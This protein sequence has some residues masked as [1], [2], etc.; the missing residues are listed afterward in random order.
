MRCSATSG[1]HGRSKSTMRRQ[2]SKLRPSPPHSVE[3]SR[4]GPSASRNCATSMSR[5]AV[6]SPSWKTAVASCARWLRAVRSHSSVSRWATNTS[7]LSPAAR[8]SRACAASHARRGSSASAS[9]ARALSAASSRPR[10]AWSDTP[11]ASARRT[12]SAFWRR[13]QRV[14][15]LRLAH[16]VHERE[17][18]L[19][20]QSVAL[21][22][23]SHARRQAADVHAPGGARAGRQRLGAREPRL[24]ALGFGEV[25]GPQQLQQPEEAVHVV[26]ERDRREQQQVASERRDRG[27]R[28]PGRVAGMARRPPQPVR[29]VDHQQVDASLGRPGGELGPRDERFDR[30]HGARVHLERVEVGAEVARH[31][32]EAGVV[33]QHEDLVV[34]PPQLAQPLHRERLG[35][36]HEAALGASGPDEAAQHQ[37]GLD[38]LA[39]A[40]LVGEEPAHRVGRG[41]PL[42]RVELVREEPDPPAQERSRGRSPRGA[43]RGGARR[44]AAPGPRPGRGRVSRGV[45]P[46]RRADPA[47]RFRRVLSRG[48]RER[49]PRAAASPRSRTRPRPSGRRPRR[50]GPS[51]APGCARA[52]SG[53][54]RAT[55]FTRAL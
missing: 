26:V 2:N 44:A 37:A 38:R 47:A 4:L 21:D 46:G 20:G 9:A 32:G 41:R 1:F 50:R 10:S 14:R 23:D 25:G 19:P 55:R 45:P 15:R 8:Q 12:R 40:D 27:D 24:E 54:P 3:T 42:R 52:A 28:P 39:E 48:A 34:L 29:L 31:V 6:E 5:R 22:R 7:V 53:R 43:R 11:D 16:R 36:D 49:S 51:R 35:S 13:P 18:A 17:A 33:E 30:D